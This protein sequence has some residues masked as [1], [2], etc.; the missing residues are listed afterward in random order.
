V[1]CSGHFLLLSSAPFLVLGAYLP[2]GLV[3]F[4]LTPDGGI[5]APEIAFGSE[6]EL[7]QQD[8]LSLLVFG[9]TADRLTSSEQASLGGQAPGFAA[10]LAAGM[11]EQTV[12]KALG[13][14]TITVELGDQGG[15][16]SIG[17]GRYL[18]QD[19]FVEVTQRSRDPREGNRTGTAVTAEFSIIRDLDLRVTGSD[20]GE[21]AIDFVWGRDY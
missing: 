20:F 19:V 9:R 6:P 1:P 15:A 3:G 11:L 18:T 5:G 8:I 12:G 14:D 17:A 2:E 4:L 21:T 10:G 16:T 7:N 13:L